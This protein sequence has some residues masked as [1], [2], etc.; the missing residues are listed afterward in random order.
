MKQAYDFFFLAYTE[1][2]AL[3]I[4]LEFIASIFGVVSVYFAKKA[5]I[6]VYP[7]G[8]VCTVITVYLL[9]KSK[10]FGDMMM[11]IYYSAMSIYG[12]WK[13]VQPKD[14]AEEMPIT[15]AQ[16]KE[17]GLGL[18]LVI[19]TM[20]ITYGVYNWFGYELQ[21]P[22]YID[23]FTSGLFFTAMWFMAHKKIEH[24]LLWIVADIITIPL[25]AYRGL[26]MLSLQYIIFTILAIQG[27]KSWKTYLNNNLQNV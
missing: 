12:W 8:I 4:G 27:Y 3:M 9:Y 2:S 10:F 1:T 20:L 11:N 14:G 7:T 19:L 17:K 25:Y 16:P 18:L 23:I 22:N 13:W 24:W 21:I 5:H 15:N 26:G 6:F